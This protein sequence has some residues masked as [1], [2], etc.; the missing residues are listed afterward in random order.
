MWLLLSCSKEHSAVY[1][2]GLEQAVLK[3][4]LYEIG[5]ARQMAEVGG[6]S[7]HQWCCLYV[8]AWKK[9]QDVKA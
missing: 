7:P 9:E 8:C 4:P 3:Q 2:I 6:W 1:E 5:A